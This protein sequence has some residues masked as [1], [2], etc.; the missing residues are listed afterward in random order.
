[1]PFFDIVALGIVGAAFLVL[2]SSFVRQRQLRIKLA[3]RLSK[4]TQDLQ[5]SEQRREL[6]FSANP[7]AMWIY[8]CE[9]LRFLEVNDAAV[10]TYGYSPEEFRQMTLVDIRPAEDVAAFPGS[11]RQEV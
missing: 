8:D 4:T 5:D 7:Y 9:S 2:L 11:C 3:E 10:K 1:M 6:L